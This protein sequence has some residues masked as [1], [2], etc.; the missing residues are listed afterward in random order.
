MGWLKTAIT[1]LQGVSPFP[2]GCGHR[3]RWEIRSTNDQILCVARRFFKKFYHGFHRWARI[4]QNKS[5]DPVEFGRRV[6][7]VEVLR[8]PRK[9]IVWGLTA[10]CST[11]ATRRRRNRFLWEEGADAEFMSRI[12]P[13]RSKSIC[14]I[15]EIRGQFLLVP[16]TRG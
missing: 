8:A 11:P 7:G 13:F 14:E 3:P 9:R 12:T 2:F 4:K 10:F 5:T 1:I 6:A 15:R 16:S